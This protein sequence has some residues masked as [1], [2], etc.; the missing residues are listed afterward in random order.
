MNP[1][2]YLYCH[3]ALKTELFLLSRMYSCLLTLWPVE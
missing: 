3:S 1:Y 2:N